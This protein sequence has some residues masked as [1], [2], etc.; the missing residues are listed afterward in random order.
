MSPSLKTCRQTLSGDHA[1]LKEP[2]KRLQHEI[3]SQPNELMEGVGLEHRLDQPPVTSSL[4]LI[5]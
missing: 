1:H 3:P 2:K 5:A 4:V